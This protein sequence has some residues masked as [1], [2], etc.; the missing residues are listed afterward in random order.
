MARVPDLE[1][2]FPSGKEDWSRLQKYLPADLYREVQY[3]L[4]EQREA[5]CIG[6]LSQLLH[7]VVTYVPRHLALELLREPVVAENKGRF[8]EGTLLFADISGFTDLSE[9]LKEIGGKAGAEAV[10]R[11]I[12]EYLDAMLGIL[13]KYNGLLVKF[14][15]D[16]MLCLFKREDSNEEG[17]MNAL[18]AAWEM[19]QVMAE[20]FDA[21]EVFQQVFP[22]SMKAGSSSGL[23][24]AASV[25]TAEHMEYVLTG[26][27]VE[28][29]ARAESAA[30]EGDILVS[31]ETYELV[32]DHLKVE[33]LEGQSD[34]YRV[35]DVC[36][37]PTTLAGDRWSEIERWLSDLE[38]DLWGLVERLE[39]L[40][41][42]LPTGVLPQLV[43]DPQR[44]RIE[45]QHRQVTVLFANFIGM[46]EI[47]RVHGT[48]DAASIAY[49]LSQYFKAMQ[50]EVRYYGGTINKV[51]LY[52]QGDKLMIT[53]GAPEAHEKDVQR[54]A[55][56]AL[57]MQEAMGRLVSPTASALL[58]QRIG[59]N[60]GFVFAGNVGSPRCHRREYTIMGDDVNLAARLM[61]AARPGQIWVSQSVWD[62]I[63]DGFE[64]Q[65]LAPIRVKGKKDLIPVYLLQAARSV[66]VEDERVFRS[67]MVG[68]E[69]ELEALQSHFRALLS[70]RRKQIVAV[71]GEAGVG[72]TRLIEEWRQWTETLAETGEAATWLT[73][74]GRPYGQKA[75]GIFIEIVEQLLAFADDDS[76]ER[77]WSKLSAGLK[78]TFA[79][80]SPGWVDEFISKL[81]YLGHFLALDL[82]EKAG[83][84]E[85]VERLDAQALQAQTRLAVCDLLTHAA[86][87]RPLILIL[88]DLHWADSASLDM[89]KFVLDRTSDRLPLFFCLIYR[90]RRGHPV[91]QTWQ[92]IEQWHPDSHLISL[93]ELEDEDCYQ[94]VFNLLQ[95]EQLPSDFQKLILRA[96]DGN[97]LYVEEVL[98]SLVS[99]G[100]IVRGEEGGWQI[101]QAVERIR[102]PETLQQIIQSRI[103]ELDF[104]S[105]GARR[106]LWMASVIGEEFTE[107]LWLH[108][109]TS[110]GREEEEF[111]RHIRELK[112][113][114]MIREVERIEAERPRWM[115]QFRHGL[116]QQVAYENMLVEKRCA[117]HRE[118]GRWL[119]QRY[120]D[121]LPA[122]YDALAHHYERGEVWEKALAYHLKAGQKAQRAYANQEAL[123]H[124]RRALALAEGLRERGEDGGLL[125]Q[126]ITLRSGMAQVHHLIGEYEA[127][128]EGFQAVLQLLPEAELETNE[129]RRRTAAAHRGLADVHEAQGR[130]EEA[131][132]ELQA[133]LAALQMT[134]GT[135]RELALIYWGIGWVQ[136][137]QGNYDEAIAS[138][139]RGLQAAP[140]DDRTVIA[141]LY[142]TLGFTY[143]ILGEYD[144]AAAYH[145][146]SLA[147]REQLGDQAGIAKTCNNLAIVSW[148]QGDYEQAI[149]YYQRSLAIGEKIGQVAAVAWVYN[150]LGLI[151]RDQGKYDQAI[152]FYQRALTI[153]E[154]IGDQLGVAMVLGNLGEVHRDKGGLMQAVKYLQSALGK[155]AEIGDRE[156]LT[157]VHRLLAEIYLAQGDPAQA[158][159]SGRQALEV[160]DEIGARPHQAQA[161]KVLGRVHLALGQPEQA[162]AH[163]EAARRIFGDLGD[164]KGI[165]DIEAALRA[166]NADCRTATD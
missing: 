149:A 58:S 92:E 72:K 55:L 89:L 152:D 163:F 153:H 30:R 73:G 45:G 33:E 98:R 1:Q 106:A 41:P 82:S 36:P 43:Y 24:F 8:L 52:D 13:F 166:K 151:Y 48:A 68:R 42:Y 90:L 96:T 143:R 131:M 11:V 19:R 16:A 97:P 108:L 74:R 22:L 61:S 70:R 135:S 57:A 136:M 53:F 110:T 26:S 134:E 121:R 142:D 39:S 59:I 76:Q 3:A 148:R 83:L 75:N 107:D 164:E 44:G 29:T 62:Q 127:A 162:R 104:G 122:Y 50:E 147:L 125:E 116:V 14:G 114:D 86:E 158:L 12:N 79:G 160:A 54:A 47:I 145:R 32:K 111:F 17:A 120:S 93:K 67:D 35:V 6:H 5:L 155:S 140:P 25:G 15:G 7:A 94:L 139:E 150:N 100:A 49:D 109:F 117:Y 101:V 128:S 157:H 138:C 159:R 56:T 66:E 21:V 129:R 91:W 161:H 80:A 37:P 2:Y 141:D 137:R 46:S 85:R 126:I 69:A 9:R 28:R 65:A 40:T 118:V 144:R 88:E 102:V 156:G 115:Y 123:E 38:G 60:T 10:V 113:M 95:T 77:R 165:A 23:L 64:A 146:D 20:R 112:R 81:A 18:W 63:K 132:A 103:D 78:D 84:A 154:R 87:E 99:E 71:T 27:A 31:R 105:P 133:A 119:E 124:Y 51:D 130:Y 4:P 34:F